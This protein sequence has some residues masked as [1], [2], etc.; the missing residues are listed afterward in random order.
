MTARL[1]GAEFQNALTPSL[2]RQ[3]Q[4]IQFA[5]SA[6]P[7]IYLA[8]VLILEFTLPPAQTGEAMVETLAILSLAHSVLAVVAYGMSFA[9]FNNLFTE[10]RLRRSIPEGSVSTDLLVNLSLMLL[11]TGMILRLAFFE[12]SAFIGLSVCV[13]AVST[14]V[15]DGHPEFWLNC[16]T[17]LILAVFSV[18]TFPTKERVVQLFNEKLAP[19]ITSLASAVPSRT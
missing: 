2:L 7:L 11:R 6:A 18:M 13:I 1:T 3:M 5:I 15:I 14:G 19:S 4:I 9:L 12:A 10:Q 8:V 17:T 16:T